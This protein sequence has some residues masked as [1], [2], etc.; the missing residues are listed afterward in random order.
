M[1]RTAAAPS[2]CSGAELGM[3][4]Q[5]SARLHPRRRDPHRGGIGVVEDHV[6]QVDA[7][8]PEAW[9]VDV[10][11]P[12]VGELHQLELLQRA[13]RVEAQLG[14]ADD[15]RE[16]QPPQPRAAGRRRRRPRLSAPSPASV[17][18]WSWKSVSAL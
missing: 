1:W 12:Q 7:E 3:S 8:Q 4:S 15:E 11:P 16:P 10:E 14:E 13:G 17:A 9:R 5:A 6:E 18:L 2:N